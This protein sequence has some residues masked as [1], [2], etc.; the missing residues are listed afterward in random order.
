MKLKIKS[1]SE[2]EFYVAVEPADCVSEFL[3]RS[4]I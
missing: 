3:F 1:L 2:K 4:L